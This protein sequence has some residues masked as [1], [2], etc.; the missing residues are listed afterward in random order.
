M[1]QKKIRT[2][3]TNTK[4]KIEKWSNTKRSGKSNFQFNIMKT[5]SWNSSNGSKP[6]ARSKNVVFGDERTELFPLVRLG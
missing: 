5:E 3:E 4:K 6:E 1:A 2:K